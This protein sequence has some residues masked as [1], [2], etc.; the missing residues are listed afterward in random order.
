MQTVRIKAKKGGKSFLHRDEFYERELEDS[1]HS[2]TPGE[3]VKVIEGKSE[4]PFLV[5]MANPTIQQGP[6]LRVLRSFNNEKELK[7]FKPENYIT[8]S[9]DMA[10][11]KRAAFKF[12]E[13]GARLIY[14]AVDSLPGVIA[15]EYVNCVLLQINTAGMDLYRDLIRDYLKEQTK[16]DVIFLDQQEYRKME[17]LPVYDKEEIPDIEVEESGIKYIIPRNVM[18]KIGHYYD[19]RINRLKLRTW[20]EQYAGN[21]QSGVDLFCYSGS[22]GLNALSAREDL[23]MEFVD[24]GDFSKTIDQNLEL[25]NFKGRGTFTRADVFNWLKEKENEKQKFDLII[26]DPPAFSKTLKNKSKALGGYTKLHKS[27][28]K[29]CS[30]GTILA[31]GSCT[32]GVTLEELD[33]TVVQGFWE[34]GLKIQLVDIG[35]Q[36]PDHTMTSLGEREN[37]IKFLL[38]FVS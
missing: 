37:Y 12:L 32:H 13:K 33:Q 29:L 16:K 24:Q 26:S 4:A 22:W 17:G 9:I 27:L 20:I 15:D 28:A 2:R 18:Q 21:L 36:G 7:S 6:S 1:V 35:I 38:Y 23:K 8:H 34:T 19:H 3:W 11:K 25:N 30:S 31:I 10:L 5:A 14:G